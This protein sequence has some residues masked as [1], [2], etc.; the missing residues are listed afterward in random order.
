MQDARSQ[1][2]SIDVTDALVAHIARLAR[3]GV[4]AAETASIKGHF[5]KVLAMVQGLD[6]LDL[7]GVDPSVFPLS[8]QNIFGPTKRPNLSRAT[9]RFAMLRPSATA[10]FWCRASSP[11]PEAPRKRR[12]LRDGDRRL[13]RKVRLPKRP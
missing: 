7:Q 1:A 3:V 4:S 5:E 2:K 6:A 8:T 13:D 10:I 9:K 12:S 11:A